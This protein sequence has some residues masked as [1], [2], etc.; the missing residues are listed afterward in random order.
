[1][2]TNKLEALPGEI[3]SLIIT[4]CEVHP[5]KKVVEILARPKPDG[6]AINTSASALCRFYSAHHPGAD[7][8]RLAEQL[9]K[10]LRIRRQS[11][12]AAAL[13]GILA[14][15]E[16]HIL[17]ELS[18][19]KAIADLESTIKL[20]T[21]VHRNYLAEEKFN[22]KRGTFHTRAD[23]LKHLE[24]E[25]DRASQNDFDYNDAQDQTTIQPPDPTTIEDVEIQ[26]IKKMKHDAQTQQMDISLNKQT[27][28][29]HIENKIPLQNF[30]LGSGNPHPKTNTK[31][32]KSEPNIPSNPP[33]IPQIAPKND[34]SNQIPATPEPSPFRI[35]EDRV[36]TLLR[37][38]PNALPALF[39][40][41]LNKMNQNI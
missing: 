10:S 39:P 24:L 30:N 5:Y 13:T 16:N 6:L 2:K 41:G 40:N 9:G 26:Q 20:M 3:K 25:A 18:R 12:P 7:D 23:Y 37:E 36:N 32:G 38:D 22:H 11:T 8:A 14:T 31:P 34:P 21:R 35:F 27:W 1:M 19:G 17:L 15:L 33:A 28:T 29:T 4:L